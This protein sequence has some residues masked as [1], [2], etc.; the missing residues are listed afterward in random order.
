MFPNLILGSYCNAVSYT[1]LD[2]YERQVYPDIV[3]WDF[4]T[5]Y[6]NP[7]FVPIPSEVK[8]EDV[9]NEHKEAFNYL[10]ANGSAAVS[11]THLDVYKRQD[12]YFDRYCSFIY[13]ERIV[14]FSH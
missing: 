2:V 12:I 3:V 9:Q 8:I 13:N 4:A 6:T 10:M 5:F 14:K 1:H 11:Y 7:K